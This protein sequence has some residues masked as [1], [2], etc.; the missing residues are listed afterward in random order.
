MVISMS[1]EKLK[2]MNKFAEFFMDIAFQSLE[3]QKHSFSV[4]AIASVMASRKVLGIKPLWSK[5]L[6]SFTKYKYKD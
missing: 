1:K 3:L 6:E 4:Q 2:Q 5:D